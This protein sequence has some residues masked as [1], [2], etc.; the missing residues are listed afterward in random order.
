MLPPSLAMIVAGN[1]G[2]ALARTIRPAYIFSAGLV[3]A[4]VG[5]LAITRIGPATGVGWLIAALFVLYI[6]NS[7]IGVMG[8]TIIMTSTPPEKAGSAG[9]LSSTSG[10]FGLALGVAV[11]G[12]IATAVFRDRVTVPTAVPADLAGKAGEN[13]IGATTVAGQQPE[14]V[15]AGLLDSAQSAFTSGMHTVLGIAAILFAVLAVVSIVTLRHVPA[16][17]A[18]A[19]A[20]DANPDPVLTTA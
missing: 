20:S 14:P 8:N 16:T 4:A 12:S 3:L 1:V 18:S 11:F 5:A 2:P 6:G 9:S 19:P 17:G 15:G 10:E 7:P 13:I